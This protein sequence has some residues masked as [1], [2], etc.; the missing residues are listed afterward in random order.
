MIRMSDACEV[1]FMGFALDVQDNGA[2]LWVIFTAQGLRTEYAPADFAR[3][4]CALCLH[5]EE[6]P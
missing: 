3:E 4:L 2:G 1:A 6:K 5:L